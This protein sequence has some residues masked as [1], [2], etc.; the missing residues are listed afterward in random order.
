MTERTTTSPLSPPAPLALPSRT[1]RLGP[2]QVPHQRLGR[3]GAALDGVGECSLLRQ[4]AP[5][6]QRLLALGQ[7]TLTHICGRREYR[8]QN[9]PFVM[10]LGFRSYPRLSRLIL[11]VS[12]SLDKW[13]LFLGPTTKHSGGPCV[14]GWNWD[15]Q[16][17]RPVP[18]LLCH[19]SH[20]IKFLLSLLWLLRAGSF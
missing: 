12:Y 11:S 9:E 4:A 15:C 8:F 5:D 14:W 1:M 18:Y 13:V 19:P 17:A 7:V 6:L 20:S 16:R 10:S 2:L 3:T